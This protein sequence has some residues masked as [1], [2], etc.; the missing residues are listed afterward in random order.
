MATG[1][2]K[3]PAGVTWI[4][5]AVGHLRVSL[6]RSEEAALHVAQVRDL[7]DEIFV[8]YRLAFGNS[9]APAVEAASEMMEAASTLTELVLGRLEK[10]KEAI[11]EYSAIIAPLIS[12]TDSG[13]VRSSPSGEEL[14]ETARRP[15]SL[16]EF[17][18]VSVREGERATAIFNA[19]RKDVHGVV[20]LLRP[21]DQSGFAT[22]THPPTVQ[23]APPVP[24]PA[25]GDDPAIT[26]TLTIVAAMKILQV[27]A[28]K[29]GDIFKRW[30][31]M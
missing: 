5:F 31:R 29:L 22:G 2:K 25:G 13:Q 19:G 6:D 26:A 3:K 20:D 15:R 10:A 21:P 14:L 4:N 1:G 11:R 12:L 17:A 27:A 9:D 23:L 18:N 30:R 16:E 7:S 8:R 28:S 24:G